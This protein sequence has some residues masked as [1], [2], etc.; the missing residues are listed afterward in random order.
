VGGLN[1][2]QVAQILGRNPGAVRMLQHRA[3]QK[4]QKIP[5]GP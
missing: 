4:L 5:T 2:D 1:V 3:L